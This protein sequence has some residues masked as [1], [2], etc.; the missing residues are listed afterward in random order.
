MISNEVFSKI[1]EIYSTHKVKG[2]KLF[3]DI[4]LA[5]KICKVLENY[6]IIIKIDFEF[7][8]K[9]EKSKRYEI[10]GTT[11]ATDESFND[12]L[13]ILTLPKIK[14]AVEENGGFA[15]YTDYSSTTNFK[16]GAVIIHVHYCRSE[17]ENDRLFKFLMEQEKKE[18]RA[19]AKFR[20]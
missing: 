11:N 5:S 3:S 2:D 13:L 9:E 4:E 6:R 18:R 14:N 12:N 15:K 10:L 19:N 8:L 20:M 1:Q 16:D 17:K 7:P